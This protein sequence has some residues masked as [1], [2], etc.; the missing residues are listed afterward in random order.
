[1]RVN[2]GTH[3]SGTSG[4][5]QDNKSQPIQGRK[6]LFRTAAVGAC[7]LGDASVIIAAA[8]LAALMRFRSLGEGN[9]R[10]LLLIVLPSYFLAALVFRSYRLS[11]LTNPA[12]SAFRALAPLLIALALTV[13]AAYA[14]KVGHHYSRLESGYMAA[15]A[16][17]SLVAWRVLMAFALSRFETFI[18]PSVAVLGD[19]STQPLQNAATIF[20][21]RGQLKPSLSDDPKFLD[22]LSKRFHGFDRI[23]LSFEDFKLRNAWIEVMRRTGLQTEVLAPHFSGTIPL[24]LRQLAGSP[25]LVIS[26]GPL[27]IRERAGKRVFDL[28]VTLLS[29]PLL[30]PLL[31]LI[32]MA[33]KLDSRGPVLFIQRRVGQ[34]NRQFNCYKFRTMKSE[35]NDPK[36]DRSASRDDHRL[37]RV[38][39]FLRRTSFDE[40]PQ[41]FNVIR[42]EMSLVG[43]RPHALGSTAEGQLFWE[44]A[45][46][47][48]L[49][50]AV[51]PGM[52]GL[53]QVRG[54]RGATQ[55][56][57]ELEQR[58]ASD[59]EYMNSWS[60]WLDVKILL[61][62]PTVLV[63][64]KAY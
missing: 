25:T 5:S 54:F 15:F 57:D 62:T 58:V 53:A 41:I 7:A 49:R 13:T 22:E 55:S 46:G 4:A 19:D 63:H 12:K 10:D 33:L 39:R 38:G 51:K 35:T 47:Y 34:N 6:N 32:A 64:E 14:F 23:V 17:M 48:W 56:Q 16:A 29:A 59:L 40:L 1:M 28:T 50:H 8:L 27:S 31:C 36:G 26:R 61:R 37:T 24:A 11:D 43:P 21:V 9:T 42:G 20:D 3:I 60:F 44:A 30:V 2:A 45:E 52:T 18:K